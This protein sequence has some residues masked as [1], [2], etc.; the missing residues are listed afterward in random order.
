MDLAS[1]TFTGAEATCPLMM[2]FLET[3]HNQRAACSGEWLRSLL[4]HVDRDLDEISQHLYSARWWHDQLS[5]ILAL[6]YLL[7][8]MPAS[9]GATHVVDFNIN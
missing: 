8:R 6:P 3:R 7:M 5:S 2:F 1:S 4:C 9:L